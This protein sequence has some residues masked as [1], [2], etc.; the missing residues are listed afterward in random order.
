MGGLLIILGLVVGISSLSNDYPS[1]AI[2]AFVVAVGGLL[3]LLVSVRGVR[4]RSSARTQYGIRKGQVLATSK[5][6]SR[7]GNRKA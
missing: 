7:R 6:A 3:L 1:F 2:A 5:V 4:V